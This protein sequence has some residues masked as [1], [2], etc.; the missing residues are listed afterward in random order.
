[1][2]QIF[3][4]RLRQGAFWESATRQP[5]RRV[6]VKAAIERYTKDLQIPRRGPGPI[7]KP[8]MAKL[9]GFPRFPLRAMPQQHQESL[10]LLILLGKVQG[11]LSYPVPGVYVLALPQ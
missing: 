2:S 8:E 1:M 5:H 10:V 3:T 6:Q 11:G 7:F 4:S 9:F